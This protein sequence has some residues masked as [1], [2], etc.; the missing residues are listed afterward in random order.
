MKKVLAIFMALVLLVPMGLVANAAES[1]EVKPFYGL[2]WSD[3]NESKFPYMNGNARMSIKQSGGKVTLSYGGAK[4]T[5]GSIDEAQLDKMVQAM[6]TELNSRPQGSRYIHFFGPATAL[7]LN[8]ENVVYL[9][10]GVDQLKE[11]TTAFFAK[12]YAAGGLVDGA[13]MSVL[14][15]G[16][17]SWYIY[18][19]DAKKDRLIYKKIVDDPRYQT[20]IRPLLAERGFKFYEKITDETPEIYSISNNAESKY[21]ISQRIWD[22]VMRNRLNAY[23]TEWCYEPMAQY[24]PDVY[25]SDYQSTNNDSWLKNVNGDGD[26][27]GSGGNSIQVGNTSCQNFY[28]SRPSGDFYKNNTTPV[29]K[30]PASYNEAVYEDSSFNSFRYD[31]NVA[32]NVY[33]SS[34]DGRVCYWISNYKNK[35][36]DE[37]AITN[38]PYYSEQAFHLNLLDPKP[39]MV[40]LPREYS[41]TI[42]EYEDSVNVVNQLLAELT[43]VAGFAD[44]KPIAVPA[45]WNSEFVLSGM[46]A[47]GRNIWRITPNTDEVSKEAFQVEGTD[48]TFYVK[49]QTITFPGGKILADSAISHI[50]TCG[51]WVE[52]AADITPIIT[53][54]ADRYEKYPTYK[55]DYESYA[56][57]AELAT[58]NLRDPGAW[59][60][61]P[62]GTA[63]TVITDGEDKALSLTGNSLLQN[64]LL[65]ANITAGDTYAKEQSWEI[66]VTVPAG[67]TAEEILTFLDFTA[68]KQSAKDGGFRITGGKLYYS[69]LGPVDEKGKA[70]Q[71]YAELMDISAGGKFTFK[72]IMHFNNAESYTCDYIVLDADGKEVAN[73]KAVAIPNFSDT[74]TGIGVTCKKVTGTILLDD[75]ILRAL[76]AAADLSLYDAAFGMQIT[77]EAPQA[78]NTAYRLS[79]LNATEREES[80]VVMAA[81]YEGDKKISD[82]AIAEIKMAP[83]YDGV[84]TG[85]V[86]IQEGQSVKVYLKTSLSGSSVSNVGDAEAPMSLVLIAVISVIALF[87][88][89]GAVI[90]IALKKTKK[91]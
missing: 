36:G 21:A 58:T 62:K 55:E 7:G 56:A 44:R 91:A 76:G 74:V 79:W 10:Y 20:E 19:E 2:G 85:I 89:I 52:T 32:K 43:R 80:A 71:E 66:T 45:T 11:L 90:F 4:I 28:A 48:P 54:D 64:K 33:A 57:G 24:F 17:G 50:G 53:N 37:T 26:T 25:V 70:A 41:A 16:M 87:L 39:F 47:N 77:D 73:A 3:F 14:Y 72:R 88:A 83:G 49:G 61:Q 65:P 68:N 59:I 75:F 69:K 30:K 84:K 8:P 31:M 13:V 5:A 40:F 67:M 9:D 23:T 46:Y 22:T 15:T 12:Y 51:Y 18:S 35:E 6:K 78:T 86:E 34:D 42:E 27:L 82:T 29:Y 63:L 1:V 60:V 38:S 81:V